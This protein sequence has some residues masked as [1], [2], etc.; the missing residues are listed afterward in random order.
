MHNVQSLT[1]KWHQIGSNNNTANA[2]KAEVSVGCAMVATN[3]TT[4]WL[5]FKSSSIVKLVTIIY[6]CNI[7]CVISAILTGN[8]QISAGRSLLNLAL[9]Q[10]QI[11]QEFLGLLY[12]MPYFVYHQL[13]TFLPLLDQ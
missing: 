11:I 2:R 7:L 5:D 12:S 9:K 10:S 13:F 1:T 3:L 4:S 8:P 6:H